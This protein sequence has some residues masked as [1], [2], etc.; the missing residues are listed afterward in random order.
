[1]FQTPIICMKRREL[2]KLVTLTSGAALAVPLSASLLTAC[3]K[4][5]RVEKSSYSPH[6]FKAEEFELLGNLIDFIL[7]KTETPSALEVG[8]DQIIDTMVGTVY[9]SEQKDQFSVS[10]EM[11]KPYGASKTKFN[12]IKRVAISTD[13]K[14]Q[15]VKDAFL[16]LKQQT[17]AYYLSTEEIATKYLNYLPV[18]GKYEPCISM[19]SVGGKAWAL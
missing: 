3:N 1:M 6:F 16:K 15:P 19:E 13:E 11:L 5:E 7:P 17:I 18:P 12:E 4:V 8:V 10:F 14:D 9:S 2:I